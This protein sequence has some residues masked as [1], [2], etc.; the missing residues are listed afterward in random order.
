MRPLCTAA[1]TVSAGSNPPTAGSSLLPNRKNCSP[2]VCAVFVACQKCASS[3]LVSF[4]PS[5]TLVVSRS[6]SQSSRRLSREQLFSRHLRWNTWLRRSS[7]MVCF[8]PRCG[9]GTPSLLTISLPDC[10]K[11]YTHNT[12]RASVQVRQK[13]P[14]KRTFLYL[15]QLILKNGAHK[16]T[17][18][19]KE[20]KDGLDFF[21]AQRN[22]AEKMVDFLCSV[23]PCKTKK[24]QELISM[25]IHT[26]TKSY[27]SV[28]NIDHQ[29]L[30]NSNLISL[31]SPSPLN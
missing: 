4:G 5:P 12:W 3:T 9:S 11:S 19:I 17:V 29:G 28:P 20:A 21:F 15:E 16:D 10:K 18:N 14:H 27:K 23:V 30:F 6:R 25:D 24:S 8:R 2:F 7:V 13:V 31:G 22:H 1:E 26:S